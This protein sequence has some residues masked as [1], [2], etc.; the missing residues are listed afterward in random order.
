[1]DRAGKTLLCGARVYV[2]GHT[3]LAGSAILRRLQLERCDQVITRTH[4][5]LNL[6]NQV[7]VRDFFEEQKPEY[8]FLAAAKVGGILANDSRPAEFI[9]E[10]LAIQTNVIRAAYEA[11][12][13]RLL[14]LGSSCI[15]PRDSPQ[16]IREEYLLTGPLEKTNRS[17]AVAKIAG[18]EMCW[19]F[20]RQFGTRFLA[21]MPANLYGLN[22]NYDLATAHVLAALLRKT[23]EAKCDGKPEVSVWGTGGAR[24][25]FLH[26]DDM[27][28]ACVF[29]MNLENA[30]YDALASFADKPPLVNVGC[31]TDL[32]V[33][34][35]AEL[36]A[37]VVGFNGDLTFD[38]SKPD[39]TPR[40]L[41]DVSRLAQLGWRPRIGFRD[42]IVSVYAAYV[43]ETNEPASRPLMSAAVRKT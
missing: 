38:R 4:L 12:V 43:S 39:G 25:E 6:T 36:I 23:H 9:Y 14:F 21:A 30:K 20:N 22:D 15:Y 27:A 29:L 3:G 1:M 5:Q 8:V 2:A 11:G 42:G 19:A 32:S 34:E 41:L 24:R 33:R 13:K 37:D 40:K 17:Y 16:P 35:L 10:N 18:I 26:S 28:D 31:G 7:S